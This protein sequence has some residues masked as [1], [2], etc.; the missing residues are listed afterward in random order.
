MNKT[1]T[2]VIFINQIREKVG[3][4]FGN[5]EVTPGGRALKFYA[6]VRLEIRLR[7][8]LKEGNDFIGQRVKIKVVKN[9][10]ASPFQEVEPTIY[11]ERGIDRTSEL[12]DL[13]ISKDIM[14]K[15]GS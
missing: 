11:Y 15:A 1:G 14:T 9:K 12:I 2:T 7:E 4:I 6:S 13:A 10:V 5:P 3:I 8:R